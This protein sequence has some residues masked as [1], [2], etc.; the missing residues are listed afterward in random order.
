MFEPV[1]SKIS[2]PAASPYAAS[3]LPR[4]TFGIIVLNGEPFTRYCLRALY[5]FAHQI[6]VVEGAVRAAAETAT[7][8][9]HSTDGTLE[10]LYR[11]KAEEDT[12]DKLQIVTRDR[13]WSEKDEQ[14]RAYAARA[15]G[16]YLWQVDIDEF[17]QPADMLAVLQ[18]LRNDPEIS[19]SS[20]KQI[21]FWGGFDY[22][23]DGWYLQRG[24]ALYSRLFRWQT[25]HR[26]ITHRPPTVFDRAGKDLRQLRWLDGNVLASRGIF[27][28]HYSLVFP[29]QVIEKCN[30]YSVAEW[31]NHA[32]AS[33]E[34]AEHSFLRL[35]TPFHVHNVYSY[36]SWLERFSG[37]H[38]PIVEELISDIQAGRVEIGL[39]QNRDVEE[40]L[41][42]L[43]YRLG[44]WMLRAVGVADKYGYAVAHSLAKFVKK[45][46][47]KTY[48]E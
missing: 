8:D 12:Q 33:K 40:L 30:Y 11:F 34:W 26:Y 16:E 28:Y 29:K 14:S 27:L 9:G 23:T 35:Q 46:K 36:P 10:S 48:H 31:A 7:A 39:R 13:F 45:S 19:G 18:T 38:P 22:I 41:R 4:V 47:L 37:K 24:A 32:R 42:S 5:P 43:K 20:F 15:N 44:R 3:S 6:I 25:G 17:Y 1:P 2:H 21:T